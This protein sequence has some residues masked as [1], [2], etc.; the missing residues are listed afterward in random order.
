MKIMIFVTS[1]WRNTYKTGPYLE[2]WISQDTISYV[3]KT[4][5]IAFQFWQYAK[6]TIRGNII[7]L[8][9]ICSQ[10]YICVSEPLSV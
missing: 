8:P 1:L 7:M 3:W 4:D 9:P 10:V 5:K 6:T 2:V